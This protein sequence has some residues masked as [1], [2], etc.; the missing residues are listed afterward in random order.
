MISEGGGD[1]VKKWDQSQIAHR[2]FY[3]EMWELNVENGKVRW[4]MRVEVTW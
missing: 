3:Y 1:V 4:A 2:K